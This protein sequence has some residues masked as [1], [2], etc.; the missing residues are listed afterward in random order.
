MKPL[1]A[2][3]S[4]FEGAAGVEQ[5]PDGVRPRRLPLD[6]Q[7]LIHPDLLGS[8]QIPCGVRL[9]TLSDTTQLAIDIT[10]PVGEASVD[11]A[12]DGRRVETLPMPTAGRYQ[13][14]F[15]LASSGERRIELYLPTY[16]SKTVLHSV[17]IDD[18]AT[19]R[20]WTDPR[21]RW[22]AH[23]SSITACRRALSPMRAWP[24]LVASH[25]DWHHTNLGFAGQCMIDPIVARTIATMPADYISLCLGINTHYGGF[26]PRTWLAA[27]TGFVLT[28]RDGHPTTPLVIMSPIICPKCETVADGTGLTVID[29]RREL[30]GLVD[31]LRSRGDR[32]ISYLDGLS[33][34]SEADVPCMADLLHPDGGGIEVMGER[35]VAELRRLWFS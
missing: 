32:H 12:V 30:A 9:T 20:T 22:I 16:G 23:G 6:L 28:V 13:H 29:M 7:P 3:A 8:S 5:L 15:A 4:R 31:T 18:Q 24:A 35:M 10:A 25:F 33:I 14:T 17:T 26:S 27:V 19:A 2:E 34:M 21:K 11:V 1:P